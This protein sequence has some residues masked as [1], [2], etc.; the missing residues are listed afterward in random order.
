MDNRLVELGLSREGLLLVRTQAM[1]AGADATLDHPANAAGLLAY[2]HGVAAL[3]RAFVGDSW[4]RERVENI[5]F[6][7][8]DNLKVRVGFSNVKLAANDAVQP[9]ARSPKG[10]GAARVCQFTI[11]MFGGTSSSV[12]SIDDFSTYFLMID[13][14]GAAELSRPTVT[15]SNYS[16]YLERIYLSDGSDF[17]GVSLLIDDDDIVDDFDPVVA[18]K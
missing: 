3:R 11:D 10:A 14:K 7:R 1:A 15:R 4:S 6:I 2:I 12:T 13:P 9:Q 16:D 17:D 5:E 18:R 8:N